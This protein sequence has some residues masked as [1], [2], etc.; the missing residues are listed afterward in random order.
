MINNDYSVPDYWYRNEFAWWSHVDHCMDLC[1]IVYE[2]PTGEGEAI[3]VYDQLVADRGLNP[4]MNK[5]VRELGGL[6]VLQHI[7][8]QQLLE[9]NTKF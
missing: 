3:P 2:V 8:Q 1:P 7:R 9:G 6:S 5:V 4:M